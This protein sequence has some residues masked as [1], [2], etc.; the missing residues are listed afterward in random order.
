M[1]REWKEY[2]IG[3]IAEIVGGSTPPTADPSNFDGDIPWLTP[4]DLSYLQ[5]RYVFR[6]AR[7]LSRKGIEN[8]SARLLPKGT[9]LLTSRAPIGYLAIAG[10]PIATNQGFRNLILKPGFN[11]EFIYYWLKANID[12]LERH[13]SGSTFKELTGSALAE[14][15]ICVPPFPEQQAIA[16]IL[17][18]LDDKIELNRK[19]N[20]TLEQMARALFKSWFIDFEPVRAK[21][22]GRWK[23]GQSL[24]GLPAHLYDLFPNRL[25][26]TQY[27][28][29][30]AGWEFKYFEDLVYARQGKYLSDNEIMSNQTNEFLIPVWGGNGIRG[31]TKKTMYQKPIVILTCRGSNCGMIN[32]SE[33]ASW[34]TN[35]AFACE[36]KIGSTYFIYI[37]L[38]FCSFKDYVSGSAQPQITYNNIKKMKLPF[39]ISVDICNIYSEF[40]FHIFKNISLNKR[41]IQFLSSIRDRLLPKLIRGEIRLNE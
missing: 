12:V 34:V 15:I 5:E 32:L 2:R 29:I 18:T 17:G 36:P 4:K 11:P 24:P 25:V 39:P 14:I 9:V 13:A 1:A 21:M 6:G 40:I 22:E 38:N 8:C 26:K 41:E 23:K 30:P 27:G 33:V 20:E 31:Y 16:H 10:N 3:E 28:L 37:Y 19:M 35:I 7:N